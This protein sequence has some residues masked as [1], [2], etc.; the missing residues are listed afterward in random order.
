MKAIVAALGALALGI[1]LATAA[2]AETPAPPAYETVFAEATTSTFDLQVAGTYPARSEVLVKLTNGNQYAIPVPEG[3]D[4]SVWRE[5]M[6]V[7]VTITQGLVMDLAEGAGQEPGYAFEVVTG[8]ELTGIPEDI[9]V[10]QITYVTPVEEI[11]VEERTVTFVAPA[12]D[13]RTALVA[14]TVDI[15]TFSEEEAMLTLTYF[16]SVDIA[17]R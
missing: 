8:E 4:L 15:T 12:G 14:E 6:L 11:D 1:P 13:K 9:L 3:S 16:D 17:R 7:R 2:I 5:N 10:R